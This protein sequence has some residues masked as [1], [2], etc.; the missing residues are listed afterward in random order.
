MGDPV[1]VPAP[2]HGIG[3]EAVVVARRAGRAQVAPAHVLVDAAEVVPV[4]DERDHEPQAELAGL[5]DDV[6]ELPDPVRPVVVRGPA[7]G[8]VP[9]LEVD[10]LLRPAADPRRAVR[11]V[12]D[13]ERAPDAHHVEALRLRGLEQ[14]VDHERR[15]VDRVV[16]VRAGEPELA[17]VEPELRPGAL[18][19]AAVVVVGRGR[20]GRG[21]RQQGRREERQQNCEPGMHGSSNPPVSGRWVTILNRFSKWSRKADRTPLF[22]R[23]STG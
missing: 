11:G 15:L 2:D 20:D 21:Q 13:V 4:V 19:E 18:D 10:A 23:V 6:V 1:P 5:R 8:G 12:A 16:V 9:V 17:A 22:E 14:V 7:R 3:V